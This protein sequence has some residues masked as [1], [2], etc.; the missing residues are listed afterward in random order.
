MAGIKITIPLVDGS[1][2]GHSP[3]Y[4]SGKEF[5]DKVISD[6]I[7]PPP[8]HLVIESVTGDGRPLRIVVPYSA[9]EAITVLVDGMK[10]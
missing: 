1:E 4:A 2:Y 5:I 10:V 8:R 3:E 9:T 7:K 6:D